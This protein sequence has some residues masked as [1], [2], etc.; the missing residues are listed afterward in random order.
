MR[1]RPKRRGEV[2][3][4]LSVDAGD[5]TARLRTYFRSPSA[6]ALDSRVVNRRVTVRRS[7]SS[8]GGW[9]SLRTTYIVGEVSSCDGSTL[10][11]WR[12]KIR[13]G[14]ALFVGGQIALTGAVLGIALFLMSQYGLIPLL[15]S[16]GVGLAV[17]GFGWRG[18]LSLTAPDPYLVSHLAAALDG[19]VIVGEFGGA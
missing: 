3:W 19:T 16:I 5:A 17:L 1:L 4:R 2:V 7:L 11:R 13:I 12:A 14:Q 8:T 15:F 6:G 10:L 9:F 18:A